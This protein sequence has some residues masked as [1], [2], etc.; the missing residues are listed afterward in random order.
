M[1]RELKKF[2][3][4]VFDLTAHLAWETGVSKGM[5]KISLTNEL[6]RVNWGHWPYDTVWALSPAIALGNRTVRLALGACHRG[7]DFIGDHVVCVFIDGKLDV[8]GGRYSRWTVP[9]WWSSHVARSLIRGNGFPPRGSS[10]RTRL[11]E[12]ARVKLK[13]EFKAKAMEKIDSEGALSLVVSDS[14][15]GGETG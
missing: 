5:G 6:H 10:E 2:A 1:S 13:T 4:L 15:K 3:R 9:W 11:I 8:P 12:D 14:E 7:H